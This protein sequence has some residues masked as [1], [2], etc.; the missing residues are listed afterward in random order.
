MSSHKLRAVKPLFWFFM[1]S[2]SAGFLPAGCAKA[3]PVLEKQTLFYLSYGKMEDQLDAY[4]EEGRQS[5]F[6]DRLLMRD[7]L[8]Y[9]SNSASSKIMIFNSYG[10]I[11]NL[12]FNREVNPDPVL[13]RAASGGATRRLYEYPFRDLGEIAL[14]PDKLLLADDRVAEDRMEYDPQL[15]AMFNRI[16]LQFD[17]EGNFI[18]YLGQEGPGGTPFPYIDKLRVTGEKELVVFTKNPSGWKVFWFSP[19]GKPLYTAEIANE[20]LPV[21]SDRVRDYGFA[22]LETL[23]SSLSSGRLYLKIDS[24]LDYDKIPNTDRRGIEFFS[25]QLWTL[26][27]PEGRY[28]SGVEIPG[29]A[30]SD[31]QGTGGEAALVYEFIGTAKEDY[32]FFICL[33]GGNRYNLM[34]MDALGR[35]L[36]RRDISLGEGKLMFKEFQVSSGGILSALIGWEDRAEVAWWRVD[37]LGNWEG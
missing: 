28:L 1:G 5:L 20:N 24:Y 8:F 2:L 35:V 34:V 31:P 32:C 4:H 9:L 29:Y 30:V 17:G 26:D 21:S 22:V 14:S 10:D 3:A 19:Q 23:D 27:A 25:S 37:E 12:Y 13:L 6:K 7:G 11:I 18:D 36:I 33:A 16:V 15:G